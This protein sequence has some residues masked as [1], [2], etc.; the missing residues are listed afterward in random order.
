MHVF[1]YISKVHHGIVVCSASCPILS[2]LMMVSN[3]LFN[4]DR[5]TV[6]VKQPKKNMIVGNEIRYVL[7]P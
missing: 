4:E 2:V 6:R 7:C 3:A 1:R 5:I